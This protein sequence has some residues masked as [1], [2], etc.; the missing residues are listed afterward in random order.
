MVLTLPDADGN[1]NQYLQ[2]NGSGTL[3][4]NT[5]STNFLPNDGPSF[6]AKIS[7]NYALTHNTNAKIS[8]DQEVYDT[9]SCYDTT[10]YRFTPNVA[11]YYLFHITTVIL[12]TASDPTERVLCLRKYDVHQTS[13]IMSDRGSAGGYSGVTHS[14][15]IEANGSTDYFEAF[16]YYWDSDSESFNI[17]G[18]IYSQFTGALIREA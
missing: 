10:N 3:S 14:T 4:W 2:T 9:A 8:F 6:Q 18:G 7:S 12:N 15:I 5:I 1:A 17:A 16:F 11:G 13:T